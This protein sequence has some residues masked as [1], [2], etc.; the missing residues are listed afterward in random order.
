MILTI[1]SFKIQ[2]IGIK[3]KLSNVE[4]HP[5]INLYWR[6]LFTCSH[7]LQLSST[8]YTSLDTDNVCPLPKIWIESLVLHITFRLHNFYDNMDNKINFSANFRTER[9]QRIIFENSGNKHILL[10]H[11]L[12][13]YNE[14][15]WY[16]FVSFGCSIHMR[17]NIFKNNCFGHQIVNC[18]MVLVLHQ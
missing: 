14:Y 2:I 13:L 4:I 8:K 5:S 16:T 12:Y 15:V 11:S 3:T 6:E 9:K 10:S 7:Q 1:I 18:K 17:S